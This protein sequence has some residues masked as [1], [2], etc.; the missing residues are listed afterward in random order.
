MQKILKT[1][2]YT[3]VNEFLEDLEYIEEFIHSLIIGFLTA[4]VAILIIIL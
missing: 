3:E 1:L 4:I 2:Q